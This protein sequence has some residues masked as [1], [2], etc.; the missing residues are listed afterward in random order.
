[1]HKYQ[2][3]STIKTTEEHNTKRNGKRNKKTK[4]K[5]RGK[6]HIKRKERTEWEQLHT[7]IYI[8]N[9]PTD[10]RSNLRNLTAKT[11]GVFAR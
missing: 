4:K 7:E 2:Q 8:E 5:N 3:S 6:R 10:Q 1:M 11:A 9:V